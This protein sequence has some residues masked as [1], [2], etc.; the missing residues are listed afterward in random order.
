M[1][2]SISSSTAV[3]LSR[4]PPPD[5]VEALDYETILAAMMADLVARDP[6]F[7][8][9]VESD[10][11]LKILEI[12]AWRELLLRQ[13][14]NE[15]AR[16]V[17]V[18]YAMGA[19]LDQL[20]AVFG[21]ARL[22]ITPADGDT[23]A[24][25][26]GDEALRR[27]I[28][29]A[30]DSYSVAGPA[31]AYIFHALAADGDVLDAS[32]TSPEPGEVVVSVLSRTGDGTASPEL[33]AT[34]DAALSADTVR[35]LTDSVT[36]QAAGLVA[37]DVTATLHLYAGPDATLIESAA[38]DAL[39]ARLEELRRIGRD[40]PRSVLIAALHVAGVQRVE[41]IS[42]PDDVVVDDTQAPAPGSITLSLAV[43]GE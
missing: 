43:S 2:I 25:M 26:E 31:S 39:L 22:E 38:L 23:P 42:P 41:L 10:P 34:V 6:S 30:P 13:R 27:R 11:A 40:V 7:T 9:L 37:F 18:A 16:A 8:A 12:A 32:A 21:V 20:G 29:L 4:L 24:V 14:V 36:V 1:A 15:A 3:D 19:D 33:L 17:M 35:P 28:L 5:V